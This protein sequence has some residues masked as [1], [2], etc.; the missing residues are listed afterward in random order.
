MIQLSL[1]G[2]FFCDKEGYQDL[3][4]FLIVLYLEAVD[5]DPLPVWTFEF[6]FSPDSG[7]AGLVSLN[8]TI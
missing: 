6:R 5:A 1:Q 3:H 7:I 8:T 4:S 2:T